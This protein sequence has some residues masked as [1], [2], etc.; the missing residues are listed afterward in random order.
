MDNRPTSLRLPL[1]EWLKLS[2]RGRMAAWGM[3]LAVTAFLVLNIALRPLLAARSEALASIGKQSR[4]AEPARAWHDDGSGDVPISA[5]VTRTAA[6]RDLT[7]RRI[8][9]ADEEVALAIEKAD[10]NDIVRWIAELEIEQGLRV[11]AMDMDRTTDPGIVNATMTVR[12]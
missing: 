4:S 7:I 10:F 9:A 5:V 3:I 2:G 6:A 12:R 8:E 11:V 1:R